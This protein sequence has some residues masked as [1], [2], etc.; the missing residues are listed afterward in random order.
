MSISRMSALAF[1]ISLC[2][3]TNAFSEKSIK[4]VTSIK[5][6][7]S[8][9]SA[10]IEGVSQPHL[11][12]RDASSPHT[13]QLK[14]SDVFAIKKA[15]VIFWIDEELE[16]ALS[17]SIKKL[18]DKTKSV[19]LLK[20][21]NLK[22]LDFRKD[23]SWLEHN[24]KHDEHHEKHKEHGK[25][26]AKHHDHHGHHHD[27]DEDLHVWLDPQ[28]AKIIVT[29][30]AQKLSTIYPAHKATFEKNKKK[31]IARLDTLEKDIKAKLSKVSGSPFVVFHDAFQYFEKRFDLRAVG[32]ITVD[33]EHQLTIKQI[34]HI[35]KKIKKHNVKC[36]FSEPQFS[37][38]VVNTIAK[39]LGLKVRVLD[40]LGANFKDGPDLYFN[41]MLK[42]TEN[43]A[44][45]LSK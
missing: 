22:L 1:F 9:V 44:N 23:N 29:Y 7:H 25:H 10:L 43:L 17:T 14:P 11:V 31:T 38:K 20:T 3:I 4:V 32:A 40:P 8:L 37:P 21:P 28:N 26:E 18:K 12:I 13:F 42:N 35:K 34:Q 24:E 6:I 39:R 5:P 27:H 15:D 19:K 2:F 45:C 36:I 30:V 33:P 16:T 41:L